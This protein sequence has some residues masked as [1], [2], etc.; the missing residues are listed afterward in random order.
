MGSYY[1]AQFGISLSVID[2]NLNHEV[3][4]RVI[5]HKD[6]VDVFFKFHYTKLGISLFTRTKF[7]L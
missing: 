6:V 2:S 4:Y 5:Q 1:L 7:M 3:N